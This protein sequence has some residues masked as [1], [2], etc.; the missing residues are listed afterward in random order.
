MVAA[1]RRERAESGAGD[2]AVAE[3]TTR[4]VLH[5]N[6]MREDGLLNQLGWLIWTLGWMFWG[7]LLVGP[8]LLLGKA[9]YGLGWLL[10]PRLGPVRSWP[11]LIL[12]VVAAGI[13]VGAWFAWPPSGWDSFLRAYACAQLTLGPARGAWLVRAWGWPGV[14]APASGGAVVAPVVVDVPRYEGPEE[15]DGAAPAA[16]VIAPVPVGVGLEEEEVAS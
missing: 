11:Y 9:L 6:V 13:S 14:K 3:V 4:N 16:P 2:M 8:A 15:L 10:A 7:A 12:A 5:R 1:R